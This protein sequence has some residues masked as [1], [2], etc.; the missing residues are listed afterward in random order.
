MLEAG[1]AGI[2]QRS[3][4]SHEDE[5]GAQV[6]LK[7]D[8]SCYDPY[9]HEYGE[10]TAL[11]LTDRSPFGDQRRQI[12][13]GRYFG[14]FGRLDAEFPQVKPACGSVGCGTDDHHKKQSIKVR[15]TPV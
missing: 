7:H 10:E 4:G 15:K 13:N 9:I 3:A 1:A 5:T 14:Q 12:D 2:D 6:R 11:P 8:Q